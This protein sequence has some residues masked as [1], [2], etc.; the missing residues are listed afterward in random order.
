MLRLTGE[1]KRET[2]KAIL[3][4]VT[5]S[6]NDGEPR[7]ADIWLPKSRLH[8]AE[9]G[10]D[11]DEWIVDARERELSETRFRGETVMISAVAV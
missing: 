3:L 8:I 7:S 11:V 9:N 1:V 6:L 5:V 2:E 4:N 10:Y